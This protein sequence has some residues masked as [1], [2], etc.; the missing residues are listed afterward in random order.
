MAGW[1]DAT[2]GKATVWICE[3]PT[4]QYTGNV[5]CDDDVIAKQGL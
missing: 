2:M 3:Q 1:P 4:D 5:V